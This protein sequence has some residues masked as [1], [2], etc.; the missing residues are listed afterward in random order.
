MR[1][2][3]NFQEEFSIRDIEVAGETIAAH[4]CGMS[5]IALN[6]PDH[7]CSIIRNVNGREGA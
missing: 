2:V 4:N 6:A 3:K 5:R 1:T 7:I